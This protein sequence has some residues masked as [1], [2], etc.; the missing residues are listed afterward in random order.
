MLWEAEEQ[1]GKRNTMI[2]VRLRHLMESVTRVLNMV[3]YRLLKPASVFFY[4]RFF[5]HI[6]TDSIT[7][8]N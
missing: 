1:T 4:A 2:E 6:I 8:Y 7:L 3:L 5:V